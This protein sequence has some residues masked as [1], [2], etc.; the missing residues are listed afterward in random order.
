MAIF[1]SYFIVY[2]R[3][4]YRSN[5]FMTGSLVTKI[6]NFLPLRDGTGMNEKGI[7]SRTFQLC[8]IVV[9]SPRYNCYKGNHPLRH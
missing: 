6:A 3:L 9:Y 2:Q 1:N 5:F 8:E 7:P 4:P